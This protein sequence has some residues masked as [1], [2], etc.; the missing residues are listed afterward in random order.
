MQQVEGYREIL[1]HI[2]GNSKQ[3]NVLTSIDDG[4]RNQAELKLKEL[5]SMNAVS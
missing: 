1:V 5:S 2:M 3:V 4:L